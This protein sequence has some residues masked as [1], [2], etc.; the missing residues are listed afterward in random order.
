MAFSDAEKTDIRRLCGYPA[1][2][3][4]GLLQGW[5]YYQVYGLL[6]TALSTPEQRCIGAPEQKCITDGGSKAPL[7]RGALLRP[8]HSSG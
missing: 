2:G 1:V 7:G 4:G 5:R 3:V 6:D 8:G